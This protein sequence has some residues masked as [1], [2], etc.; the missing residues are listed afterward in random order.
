[1]KINFYHQD[2][3]YSINAN[4]ITIKCVGDKIIIS[5][6]GDVEVQQ[7]QNADG[8]FDIVIPI[9]SQLGQNLK[10]LFL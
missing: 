7:D 8:Q 9:S 3:R 4:E 2:I 6:R 10:T 1:M 5:Q